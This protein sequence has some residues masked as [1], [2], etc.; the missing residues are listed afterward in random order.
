MVCNL[1][2][3]FTS[4]CK[5]YCATLSS[6]ARTRKVKELVLN[7]LKTTERLYSPKEVAGNSNSNEV[8]QHFKI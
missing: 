7:V 4:K 5:G 2:Y 3:Q 6:D 1:K 8:K